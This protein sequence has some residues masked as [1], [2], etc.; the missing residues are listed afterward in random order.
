VTN[1]TISGNGNSGTQG[2]G[3]QNLGSG[4]LTVI[5]STIS[6]NSAEFGG[7]IVDGGRVSSTVT[8]S[9]ISD[10]AATVGGGIFVEFNAPL[11][12]KNTIVANSTQGGNC[13]VSEF[14][15]SIVDGGYNLED[16]TSCGFSDENNSQPST[17][18][19]LA[20]LAENGGPTQ[21][22]ALLS[23]SPAIDKGT[24]VGQSTDQRGEPRPHDFANIDNATDGDGSDIGAFEVQPASNQAPSVSVARGGV[25]GT[26]DLQGTINLALLDPDTPAQEL[27]LSATSSNQAVV[28]DGNVT[29]GG[30]TDLSRTL[31]VSA[32]K[33]G[34]STLTVTVSDGELQGSVL[35]KVRVGTNSNNTL[36]GS[37]NAD[38]ILARRGKDTA[39]GFAAADL[40]CGRSGNDTLSGGGQADTLLGGNN[41]D[42]LTGGIGADIFGGGA[43][44]DTATDFNAGQGDTQ[45]GIP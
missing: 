29:F 28:P 13:T 10:N 42:T 35:V 33:G 16:G 37:A 34:S 26:S 25:C 4:V 14:G 43:G 32:I 15:G 18:P 36:S 45:S 9:T 17:E 19:E 27:T 39:S 24:S 8:N 44:T 11:M 30:G 38:M 2:G 41:D 21:T 40:L 3:I 5:N 23:D 20:A 12:L 22:H 7:G 6:G 31:S 1:S